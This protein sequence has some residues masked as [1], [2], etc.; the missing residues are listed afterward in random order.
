V[1]GEEEGVGRFEASKEGK[2]HIVLLSSQNGIR[3]DDLVASMKTQGSPQGQVLSS[4][5]VCR[6]RRPLHASRCSSIRYSLLDPSGQ[7]YIFPT[8]PFA[9][10]VEKKKSQCVPVSRL[11]YFPSAPE[12]LR[13]SPSWPLPPHTDALTPL[14]HKGNFPSASV[15]ESSRHCLSGERER[16][17]KCFHSKPSGSGLVCLNC[18]CC[19]NYQIS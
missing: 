3:K 14:Q 7:S 8:F 16:E 15:C 12:V 6:T 1:W 18:V 11:I 13:T 10:S 17:S 9:L 2:G 5:E 19:R 4:L